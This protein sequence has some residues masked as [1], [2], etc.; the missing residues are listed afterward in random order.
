MAKY[1]KFIK[2]AK[3]LGAVDAKIIPA[4]TVVTA[5]WVR[6]KCQFGCGGYG[7]RLCCPPN[8]PTPEQTQKMLSYYKNAILVHFDVKARINDIIPILEKEIFFNGYFKAFGMGSGPCYLCKKCPEFCV[9]PNEA[10]PAMEACGIDVFSTVRV[11][12]FPIETLDTRD[13]KGNYYG[14]VLIE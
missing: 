5:E 1:T 6:I 7:R 3:E 14:L 12:G 4:N 11:H 9:H 8:T 13:R 10:R 2:R